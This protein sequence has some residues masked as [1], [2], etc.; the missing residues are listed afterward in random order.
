LLELELGGGVDVHDMM[1]NLKLSSAFA[2]W[3]LCIEIRE[4]QR[5][6]NLPNA[7]QH[8]N[9]PTPRLS[10]PSFC[11]SSE[12]KNPRAPI[13]RIM[14]FCSTA[15]ES[16]TMHIFA[17]K[18]SSDQTSGPPPGGSSCFPGHLG[19]KDLAEKDLLLGAKGCGFAKRRE[20]MGDWAEVIFDDRANERSLR[21]G[22]DGLSNT[23]K[24]KEALD[25]AQHL[26]LQ[27]CKCL[28]G[29]EE[30][31]INNSWTRLSRSRNHD[32]GARVTA[33]NVVTMAERATRE[34]VRSE[35]LRYLVLSIGQL[36][37]AGKPSASDK[38]KHGQEKV[39]RLTDS[40]MCQCSLL[41]QLGWRSKHNSIM[42]GELVRG[43]LRAGY[44]PTTT[45]SWQLSV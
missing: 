3:Y 31:M 11:V 26:L 35:V 20:L 30:D 22:N 2:S 33:I 37:I 8:S 42:I 9:Q 43:L 16:S 1:T 23:F 38:T 17:V 34:R 12:F 27:R 5:G 44:L 4:K 39:D 13:R 29:F 15:I 14:H 21:N 6:K 10:K 41:G 40:N 25:R 28:A 24:A 32:I 18:Q 19:P 36:P 45:F 7:H